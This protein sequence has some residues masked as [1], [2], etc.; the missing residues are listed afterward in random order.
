MKITNE[1]GVLVYDRRLCKGAGPNIY[2]LIVCEAMGLPNEFVTGA[3]KTLKM[4]KQE[5]I[6]IITTKQS[7]YNSD[8]LMDECKVCKGEAQETHH[9][10]EQYTQILII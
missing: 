6:S 4:L 2:G 3:N 7:Q 5:S 1:D 8:I 9:I 10:K